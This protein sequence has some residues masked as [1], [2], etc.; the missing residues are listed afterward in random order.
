MLVALLFVLAACASSTVRPVEFENM[1]SDEVGCTVNYGNTDLY[2][3]GPLGPS[4]SEEVTPND[5]TSIRVGRTALDIVVVATVPDGGG[6]A[7]TPLNDM[8]ADGV[9]ARRAFSNGGDPGYV[10][11]CWRGDG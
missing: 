11:T 10:V 3:V 9:V 6:N 1:S 4:D 5:Y 2:I 7:A 8:P